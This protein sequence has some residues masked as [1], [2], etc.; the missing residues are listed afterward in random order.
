[1][2]SFKKS[3]YQVILICAGITVYAQ[4]GKKN[5]IGEKINLGETYIIESRI[6]GEERPLEHLYQ[7]RSW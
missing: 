1:M 4:E 3:L 2:N 6:L 5:I 7:P